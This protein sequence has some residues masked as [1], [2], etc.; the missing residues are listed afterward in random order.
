[1]AG[2]GCSKAR[3]QNRWSQSAVIY[4]EFW[5]ASAPACLLY[6]VEGKPGKSGIVLRG[7]TPAS[8]A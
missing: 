4:A 2:D 5:P 8:M 1:M 7:S 3:P 6:N